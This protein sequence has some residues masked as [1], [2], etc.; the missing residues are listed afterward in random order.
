M[1]YFVTA[2]KLSILYPPDIVACMNYF[3]F[4]VQ[5]SPNREV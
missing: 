2:G 4:P 1:V 3:I 5:Y